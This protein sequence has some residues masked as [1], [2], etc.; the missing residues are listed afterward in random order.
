MEK[1]ISKKSVRPIP[2]G[3]HSVTAYLVADNAS[4]LISFI[5]RVFGGK[6][7]FKMK[8]DEDN[9]IMHAVVSVGDSNIMIS[10]TMEGMSPHN[11]MLYLYLDNADDVYKKAI[12]ANATSVRELK[13]E[14]YGDRTG[15]VKDEW[16][17][18]WWIATHVEDVS[19]E[20]LKVRAKKMQDE[21]KTQE[22]VH[23]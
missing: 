16:G 7:M 3:Q 15:A 6:L 4:G 17:N 5:E 13:T 10:D 2:E 22:Q 14:F 8:R 19:D 11:A 23:A 1:S 18:T 21:H 12:D 20:E 9:R